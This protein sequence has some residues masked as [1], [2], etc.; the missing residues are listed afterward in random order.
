[1]RRICFATI[2]IVFIALALNTYTAEGT[3]PDSNWAEAI[4]DALRA[5]DSLITTINNFVEKI[6]TPNIEGLIYNLQTFPSELRG[7][8]NVDVR[9]LEHD[10]VLVQAIQ[11]LPFQPLVREIFHSSNLETYYLTGGLGFLLRTFKGFYDM[12]C[13]QKLLSPPQPFRGYKLP[14]DKMCSRVKEDLNKQDRFTFSTSQICVDVNT[15]SGAET[16]YPYGDTEGTSVKIACTSDN[17]CDIATALPMMAA[18]LWYKVSAFV[19]LSL[20]S[21]EVGQ[22]NKNEISAEHEDI[23]N[24]ALLIIEYTS[25]LHWNDF[26]RQAVRRRAYSDLQAA[27]TLVQ[28]RE[29]SA[30]FASLACIELKADEMCTVGDIFKIYQSLRK[31]EADIMEPKETRN[32]RLR[33]RV[34]HAKIVELKQDAL[35]HIELLGNIRSLDEN[36]RTTVKGISKYLLGLAKYDQGISEQDVAFLAGKLEEFE[37]K[38]AFLSEK[39]HTD[40]NNAM[41]P[42]M[43]SLTAQLATEVMI[44]TAKVA[45]HGNP[46]KIIFG[47]VEVGEIYEQTAEVAAAAQQLAHGG[48]LLATLA[49]VYNDLVD[50]ASKFKDNANQISNLQKMMDAIKANTVDKIAID[51]AEFIRGYGSYT[52]KVSRACLTKNDALWAA[53][54]ETT[55]DLLHGS[56]SF[57]GKAFA[58][59]PGGMLLCEKLEG[60]LAEYTALRENIFDFQFDLVDSIARVVRGNIA[61][62]LASEITVTND[63]LKASTLMLGFFMTQYRLQSEAFLYCD[64]LEYINQGKRIRAC[65]KR[66]FFHDFSLDDLIAYDAGTN[67]HLDER[68]VYVPTKPQFRGDAGFINLPSLADGNPVTFRL[69]S[70]RNWLRKYNWLT[71]E[72][73]LAPFVASFKLYLPLKSYGTET[74]KRYSKTRIQLTSIAGSSV[75]TSGVVY[76]LPLEH[77]HYVTIY[78]EGYDQSRCSRGKEIVNPYSLCD[79]LPLICD[80]MTRVPGSRIMPTILSTWKLS[81]SVE[82]GHENLKWDAPNPATDL[83]IIGK[84]KLRFLPE[85]DQKRAEINRMSEPAFGCCVG[86]TYR[87]VWSDRHCSPCPSKP[88]TSKTNLRGYYCEKGDEPVALQPPKNPSS[89]ASPT[90]SS[91]YFAF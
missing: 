23:K 79:N 5:R 33:S 50:L 75:G 54:K 72:E 81:Y 15:C 20:C 14:L 71:S 45:E 76:N 69:P 11:D 40:V 4:L 62:K 61:K 46:L 53:Y 68:F 90:S 43:V 24:M 6:D 74:N 57:G 52:P 7:L 83:L 32:L 49:N 38:A 37:N 39:L 78:E 67:Y 88:S 77:S 34:N 55:C 25:T 28:E 31:L 22:P 82:S 3:Q 73:T 60:T 58:A 27:M 51:S 19:T 16:E 2:A 35:R 65:S 10:E 17:K 29:K 1:M 56:E 18:L 66:E 70:N 84:V 9:F 12:S 48:A 13:I 80:T 47:E 89:T 8:D 42:M 63:L 26:F 91:G 86:N 41:K 64:K 87:P 85:P 44:L 59:V 21:N 30:G 36:L